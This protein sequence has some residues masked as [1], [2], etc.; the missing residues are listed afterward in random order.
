MMLARR[1]RHAIAIQFTWKFPAG[2]CCAAC[3]LL[4]GCAT[5]PAT[6]TRQQTPTTTL[7]AVSFAPAGPADHPAA[8]TGCGAPA[9]I[10]LGTSANVFIPANPATSN[11]ARTRMFR[12][13]LP[14]SY[15]AHIPTALVLVFHGAGGSAEAVD[16][17]S[18]FT[19]LAE[20]EGFIAVYPQGLM[21]DEETLWASA[22]PVDAGIDEQTFITNLLDDLQRR[23]CVDPHRIFA[24][25]FSN[26]GAMTGYLA[27]RLAGRIAAFAPASGNYYAL[28]G[29]CHPSR[30][31][32]LVVFHGTADPIVPY[33]G[34]PSAE[35]PDWPLLSIPNYLHNWAIR[36]GC[37][38][39]PTV[40]MRSGTITGQQWTGCLGSAIIVHY[41]DEGGGHSLPAQIGD[42]TAQEVIWRF[43]QTHPLP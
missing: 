5:T 26:G 41:R 15:S 17:S 11:G 37:T 42:V 28:P 12:L 31:A 32:P 35:S 8:S 34:L 24:T 3:F 13:H 23:L 10:P 21:V 30:P 39:G 16:A 43:F 4:A 40:F 18:G 25:G 33:D 9:P 19:P 14:A 2:I 20:R 22:G 36:D 1:S 7:P 29:G 6:A 38:Q 27:C